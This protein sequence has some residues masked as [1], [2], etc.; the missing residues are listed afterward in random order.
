[1]DLNVKT[2]R[3]KTVKTRKSHECWKCRKIISKGVEMKKD[4]IIVDGEISDAYWCLNSC[5]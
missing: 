1:M 4:T 3:T 2:L 5:L